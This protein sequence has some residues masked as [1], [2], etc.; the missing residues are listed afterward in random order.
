[1][2]DAFATE[3]QSYEETADGLPDTEKVE[4]EL[5]AKTDIA[6]LLVDQTAEELMSEPLTG[7]PYNFASDTSNWDL[8]AASLAEP[9][10]GSEAESLEEL[11]EGSEAEPLEEL[12]EGSQAEPLQDWSAESQTELVGEVAGTEAPINLDDT[13]FIVVNNNE[14]I[15]KVEENGMSKTKAVEEELMDEMFEEMNEEAVYIADAEA[16]MMKSDLPTRQ[17]SDE[18]ATIT[19][20]MKMT[21]DI[22]SEGSLDLQ[23]MVN[24]NIDI[25]GKL[26]I[27]GTINGDSQ[28][29]EIFADNAKINGEVRSLGSVKI[30][31]STVIIGNIFANSAVIAGAVKGDI[32]IHGPVILDTSA[33]VMGN[34]KSKSVQINNGAVIEGMCSQCYAEVNPTSFFEEFKK[35]KKDEK[36]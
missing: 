20:G 13:A 15:E 5:F 12:P 35:G 4:A 3:P 10:E 29:A 16:E 34:I 11:P 6:E 24:G 17:A 21:G 22:T 2:F 33:I 14:I 7:T 26:N 8:F 1:M 9:P 18:T 30:G 25:L 31:Q 36:K 23:G 28:A 32:D 19:A 27:T